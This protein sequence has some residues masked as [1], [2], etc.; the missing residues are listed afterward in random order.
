MDLEQILLDKNNDTEIL[1]GKKDLKDIEAEKKI[2][3][4]NLVFLLPG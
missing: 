2:M 1:N 3:R 4:I